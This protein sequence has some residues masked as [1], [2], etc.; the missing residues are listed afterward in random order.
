MCVEAAATRA[1][2]V[3][4]DGDVE[5]GR[6]ALAE[7]RRPDLSVVDDLARLQLEARR[8]GCE[9]R[10]EAACEELHRLLDLVGLAAVVR[11]TDDD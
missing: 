6:W 8:L 9:L 4:L 10:V 1:V 5:V 11:C 3:V 7:L 2:L